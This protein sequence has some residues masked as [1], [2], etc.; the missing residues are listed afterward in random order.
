V[1][2]RGELES[3][4]E[5]E[6][7]SWAL[8]LER[9]GDY[10]VLRRLRL[11][12][13]TGD[14][15]PKTG[16]R[17]GLI[18]DLETTGLDPQSAEIVEA[19][20]LRFRYSLD[21]Q[22]LEVSGEWSA[23]REPDVPLPPETTRITGITPEELAGKSIDP[24]AFCAFAAP[25]AIVIAHHAAFDRPIA[26]RMFPCLRAKPWACSLVEIGWTEAGH[27]SAALQ[28]LLRDAGL[29]S[30]SHRALPDCRALLEVLSQPLG[31]SGTALGQL[32][33]SARRLTTL[34]KVSAPFEANEQLRQRGYRFQRADRCWLKEV[35]RA[36][37]EAEETELRGLLGGH[38]Q[39]NLQQVDALSRYAL[40][41]E[42]I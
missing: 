9:S 28:A 41:Q 23:L 25:A 11:R 39:V 3:P 34:L 35:E 14:L 36:Q 15:G 31:E 32:L 10:Q 7:E 30:D 18:V 22:V 37:A 24:E 6:L 4:G 2:E 17:T 5:Q 27:S 19:A 20:G 33:L 38:L 26:E 42:E 16:T 29:F 21:G 1:G 40:P 13:V 12:P 8:Q